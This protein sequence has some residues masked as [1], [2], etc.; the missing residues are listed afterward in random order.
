MMAMR[1]PVLVPRFSAR[2]LS[3]GR[4][5]GQREEGGRER[6]SAATILEDEKKGVFRCASAASAPTPASSGCLKSNHPRGRNLDF[7]SVFRRTTNLPL[8]GTSSFCS[9]FLCS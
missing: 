9:Y 7:R 6:L 8:Q 4:F 1:A 2:H 3:L 5:V